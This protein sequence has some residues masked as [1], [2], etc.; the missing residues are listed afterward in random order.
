M[1]K[2]IPSN[3]TVPFSLLFFCRV[4]GPALTFRVGHNPKNVTTADLVQ[5]AGERSL[6]F[7]Q[8]HTMIL[9]TAFIAI[10][11]IFT[12]QATLSLSVLE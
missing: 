9:L 5:V 2:T 3:Q 11:L 12:S 4:L 8:S 1:P 6:Y 7:F 10:H